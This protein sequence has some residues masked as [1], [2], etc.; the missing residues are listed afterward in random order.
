MKNQ[1]N[2]LEKA[3]KIIDMMEKED[4]VKTHPIYRIALEMFDI[5][6]CTEEF[7]NEVVE[8]VVREARNVLGMTKKEAEEILKRVNKKK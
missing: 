2:I 6:L 1:N 5:G 3:N 8:A 4:K 7:K